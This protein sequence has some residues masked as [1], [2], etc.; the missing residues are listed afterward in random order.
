MTNTR[1]YPHGVPC[2]VDVVTTDLDEAKQFYGALFD[3]TFHDAIPTDAPGSYLIATLG[4][5]DVAAIAPAEPGD[6]IAWRTYIAVEDADATAAAVT[7]AGGTILLPPVDAGPG[8]RQA[9][10]RDPL[11]ALFHVWQPRHRLG[12]QAVNVAGT[13]N[14]SDLSTTDAATSRAFYADLFGWEF[15]DTL[16]RRPGYGAHLQAT[17]YPDILAVQKEINAPPGFEDAVAW[18]V[19]GDNNTW[20]VTFAVED[21]DSSAEKA[22]SLGAT[23][24]S[25]EDTGWTKTVTIRDPQGALLVMSQFTPEGQ[26]T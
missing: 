9:G 8:G 16:V 7:K 11:G 3:W 12:A 2:W 4:G 23:V 18:M 5:E 22:Q 1:T 21:R 13:W 14:F 20:Q 15:D 6:E 24:V 26:T 10:C 17:V 25:S 19:N